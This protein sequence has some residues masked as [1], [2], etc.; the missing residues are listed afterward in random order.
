MRGLGARAAEGSLAGA[1]SS[2]LLREAPAAAAA[3]AL[4]VLQGPRLTRLYSTARDG[5]GGEVERGA[6]RELSNQGRC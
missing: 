5:T 1:F 6:G 3:L 2:P 4:R